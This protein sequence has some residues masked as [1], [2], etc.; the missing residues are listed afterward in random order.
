MATATGAHMHRPQPCLS[1]SASYCTSERERVEIEIFFCGDVEIE[2]REKARKEEV[3]CVWRQ[4][5]TRIRSY[6][7]TCQ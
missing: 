5:Q 1:S 3:A 6:V 2:I 7:R 4:V